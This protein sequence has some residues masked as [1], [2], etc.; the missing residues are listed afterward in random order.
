MWAIALKLCLLE[1][2]SWQMTLLHMDKRGL[3]ATLHVS[4]SP[5][6]P[7]APCAAPL[8]CLDTHR[9]WTYFQICSVENSG[10]QLRFSLFVQST[11]PLKPYSKSQGCYILTFPFDN[12]W[13]F[14]NWIHAGLRSIGLW[15]LCCFYGLCGAAV[16]RGDRLTLSITL[17]D[18]YLICFQEI[19]VHFN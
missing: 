3:Q 7:T 2:L 13:A 19:M 18:T 16:T 8:T 15:F 11:S 14:D 10:Q 5:P 17:T 9:G 1:Q 12:Y 6:A 4:S